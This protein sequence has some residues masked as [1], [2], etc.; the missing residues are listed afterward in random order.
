MAGSRLR[1]PGSRAATGKHGWKDE[2]EGI[3]KRGDT[4]LRSNLVR[5]ARSSIF[6]RLRSD[7][8]GAPRL[9]AQIAEKPIN[10]VAVA[11]A[12]HNARDTWVLVRRHLT[13]SPEVTEP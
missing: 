7:G 13:P 3:S 5:S 4:Y 9:Q 2:A 10:V 12:N 11:V 6:W 8:P 1:L